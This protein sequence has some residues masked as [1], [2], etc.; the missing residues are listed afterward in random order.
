MLV[1]EVLPPTTYLRPAVGTGFCAALT[2]FSSVAVA[3]D[4]LAAHD[5]PGAA[6]AYTVLSLVAGLAAVAFGVVLG[7]SIA[8]GRDTGR[9]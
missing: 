2:T 3:A 5:H 6:A 9:K 7:R 4:Q 8:A 1:L